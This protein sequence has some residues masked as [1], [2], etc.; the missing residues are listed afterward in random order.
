MNKTTGHSGGGGVGLLGF[1]EDVGRVG[2]TFLNG[3]RLA[4]RNPVSGGHIPTWVYLKKPFTRKETN[5]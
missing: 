5:P 1:V 4:D 3:L 2:N